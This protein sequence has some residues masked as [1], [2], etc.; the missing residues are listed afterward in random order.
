MRGLKVQCPNCKRILHET[1]DSY[2][3]DI[4]PNGAMLRLIEPYKSNHWPIFGDGVMQG[5]AG[6]KRAE[7]DCPC[8]LAQLAPS[9]KLKVLESM[10]PDESEVDSEPSPAPK[11]RKKRKQNG[12]DDE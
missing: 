6:T 8:C 5:T 11:T 7:M 12:G 1:T 2:D 10:K 9:G 3:P 4:P